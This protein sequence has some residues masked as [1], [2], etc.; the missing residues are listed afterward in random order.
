MSY[1][2]ICWSLILFAC[3][4]GLGSYP[5]L[6]HNEGMYAA[7]ARDMLKSGDFIIPHLNGAPYIEK[8][9][10]LYWLMAASMALFGENEWAARLVPALALFATAWKLQRFLIRATGSQTAS[11]TAPLIFVTSLPLLAISRMVMCEAC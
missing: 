2:I 5:L 10:L 11:L 6:D 9:P 3:F 4:Y 7:I 8:P 1:R